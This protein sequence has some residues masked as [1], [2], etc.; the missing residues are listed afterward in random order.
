MLGEC[1]VK[2]A[3]HDQLVIDP[4]LTV[5]D[6]CARLHV[7]RPVMYELIN[8]GAVASI[9]I[10]TARRFR[11]GRSRTTSPPAWT[12]R[13]CESAAVKAKATRRALSDA[14]RRALSSRTLPPP[15]RSCGSSRR[16]TRSCAQP[17]PRERPAC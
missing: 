7:S 14:G 2:P 10:N 5:D 17:P 11:S 15:A 3:A 8:S 4:A 1:W 12:K 6:A 9:K 16:G 13:R